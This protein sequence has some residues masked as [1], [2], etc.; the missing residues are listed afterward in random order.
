MNSRSH[1]GIGDYGGAIAQIAQVGLDAT[2]SV[3]GA[4]LN[5][6]AGQQS[7]DVSKLRMSIVED[8]QRAEAAKLLADEKARQAA[9]P[10][11]TI[12]VD[13]TNYMLIGAII[14]GAFLFMR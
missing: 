2:F 6:K 3:W 10:S 1:T 13:A 14:L 9:A 8:R 12:N 5:R 7:A 11:Q 4:Q